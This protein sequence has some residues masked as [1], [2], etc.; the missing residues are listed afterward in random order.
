VVVNAAALVAAPEA[1]NSGS[2]YSSSDG[3]VDVGS[4]NDDYS[5]DKDGYG[6]V[7]SG[8]NVSGNDNDSNRES[9]GGGDD[10]KGGSGG[11][12]KPW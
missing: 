8:N 11:G 5:D 10:N 3:G 12:G 7:D 1:G 4:G 2:G 6:E 9:G